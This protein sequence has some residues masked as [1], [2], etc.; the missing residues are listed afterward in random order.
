[1]IPRRKV[2]PE[3]AEAAPTQPTRGG[4]SGLASQA[5]RP[6]RDPMGKVIEKDPDAAAGFQLHRIRA[7]WRSAL[8][9]ANINVYVKCVHGHMYA[10]SY[11]DVCRL[12]PIDPDYDPD[13]YR[14]EIDKAMKQARK[15]LTAVEGRKDLR[16]L[17][18][19]VDIELWKASRKYGSEMSAALA[20]TIVE[21]QA[22]RYLT[23]RIK[24]QMVESTNPVGAPILIPRFESIND[25]PLDDNGN[26]ME[27]PAEIKA[28]LAP[29]GTD[30]NPVQI[31][32]LQAL[33]ATWHGQ[34]RLVGEA[35]LLPGFTVRDVPGVSKST[36]ARVRQAVLKE[37]KSFI[38]RGLT[39]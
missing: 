35:M 27:S 8:Q 2:P 6:R 5:Y 10:E 13:V 7:A 24:N 22:G 38:S 14:T 32:Q 12:A 17:N 15:S 39:K 23:D 18:Q 11:C 3:P 37:F 16:D 33:V 36:V 20:Y 9:S 21:N 1:M 30:F 29:T 34:K 4:L 19:I 26:E 28:S 31:E 25:K